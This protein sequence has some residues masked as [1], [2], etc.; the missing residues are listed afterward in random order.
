VKFVAVYLDDVCIYNRRLDEHLELM[1]LV[2]QRFKE[3]GLKLRLKK[4][5]FG[6]H[7]MDCLGYTV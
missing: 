1:R 6:L 7:D 5:F 4:C 2:I 3:E